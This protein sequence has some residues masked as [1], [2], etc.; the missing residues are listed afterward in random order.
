VSLGLQEEQEIEQQLEEKKEK[1]PRK[2]RFPHNLRVHPKKPKK[3]KKIPYLQK[4]EPDQ[5]KKFLKDII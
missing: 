3:P 4:E 2:L 5:T 1:F